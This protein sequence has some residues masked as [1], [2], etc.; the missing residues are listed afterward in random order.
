MTDDVDV[1]QVGPVNKK[2]LAGIV[3]SVGGFIGYRYWM[4]SKTSAADTTVDD[5]STAVTSDFADGGTEPTVIGAVSPTNS[6]GADTGNTG[7]VDTGD[8]SSYGF[9]GTTNDQWTQ[10]ASTQLE[11]SDKWSY[12]DIVT[13][14]GL[15]LAEK[16]TTAAQQQIVTS[17]IA[18][19]GYPPVGSHVLILAAVPTT[20]VGTTTPVT[21]PVATALKAPGK[22]TVSHIT[23]SSAT[24]AWTAVPGAASYVLST[25]GKDHKTAGTSLAV[26]GYG[27]PGKTYNAHVKAVDS[28]GKFSAWSA[29]TSFTTAKK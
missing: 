20:P 23:K 11:Q 4:S 9:H 21:T 7:T 8:S 15:Y 2:V 6:Y 1:P 26:T 19:A 13:A 28:K 17:A 27:T 24:I 25:D 10:Y 22:P 16:P 14:L 18:V 12:T 5:T 3:V 29:N